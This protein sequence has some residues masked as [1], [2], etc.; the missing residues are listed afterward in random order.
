MGDWEQSKQEFIDK[1]GHADKIF[2]EIFNVDADALVIQGEERDEL[3]K[4]QAANKKILNKLRSREF[5][6]AIVGLEKAG[7][8][9]L[10][11]A[12]IK[13]MV[14]PE[15]ESRCTYTTT[16]IRAG[17]TDIAEV[18]FYGV[19]EFNKNFQRMLRDVQFPNEVDFDAM[20]LETFTRY[21]QTVETES[22]EDPVKR[23]IF[24]LHNGATAEDL[25][26]IL[27]GKNKIKSLLGQQSK[28][29]GAEYWNSN[30]K[31]NEFKTYVTGMTGIN[32]DGTPRRDPS[33]YAVKNI[34]IR[35]TQLADMS[36]IVLYDVP[37]FDS[38]TELHKRQTEEMLKEADAIILV[39]NVG[40]RPNLVGTQL[41]M[42]RKGQDF[43]GVRLSE[44]SFVFGNKIDRV[45]KLETA[46]RN[47]ATLRQDAVDK[48]RITLSNHII[49]GSARAYLEK[50]G[51]FAE[52]FSSPIL[53]E[54]KYPDG[55]EILIKK[56]QEYYDHDR[57][58]VLRRRAENI[59]AKTQPF[60]RKLLERYDD[61]GISYINPGTEIL[62][63][64]QSRLPLFIKSAKKITDSHK[65]R[66]NRER[67]FTTTLK[68]EV[69]KIFPLIQEA[70]TKLIDDIESESFINTDN[71]YPTSEVDKNVRREISKIFTENIVKSAA[72]I[73]SEKQQQLRQELVDSFLTA[74][75]IEGGIFYRADLNKSVN[76]LFDAML[77]EGGAKCS[78]TSLVER[79]ASTPIQALIGEPFTEPERRNKVKEA[80]EE[81]VS[82]A[83]F[84]K[85]PSDAAGKKSLKFE[86]LIEGGENFFAKILAHEGVETPSYTA[87]NQTGDFAEIEK[88]LNKFFTK[89]RKQIFGSDSFNINSL[90]ISNWANIMA[91]ANI[92]VTAILPAIGQLT[93]GGDDWKKL[94]AD[95]KIRAIDQVIR[96]CAQEN[97]TKSFVE[98]KTPKT[99]SRNNSDGNQNSK[100]ETILGMLDEIQ[101]RAEKLKRLDGKEDMMAT[102]NTDIMILRDIT[103]KAVINAIGLER[104]FNSVIVKNVDLIRDHLSNPEGD[105]N[106]IYRAWI[107]KN[108]AK[109]KPT[110]FARI[111]DD[112]TIR[113]SRKAIVNAIKELFVDWN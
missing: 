61:T 113:E 21:W 23:T 48:Y 90:P 58:A 6:V 9:T 15:Y 10:G 37:G 7:K 47:F 26:E 88:T 97:V 46:E 31:F 65:E 105:G 86:Q 75:D 33:P 38:P 25:K 99:K 40:D 63:K 68:S 73:T 60:F 24:N 76:E 13:S 54:W 112:E 108:A 82:F 84:Y 101:E 78:F 107:R 106:E 56:M 4:L 19:D 12:L 49:A 95:E 50:I 111:E 8:S 79:F 3:R 22:A 45:D 94:P 20:T 62:M 81:F 91:E 51:L 110:E 43:D 39:T 34:I 17:D 67:P 29:F 98:S 57:F 77:I 32:A 28:K 18:Y 69:D 70:F 64:I 36:H 66:I 11:N 80:L 100:A 87:P 104:A 14:L 109:L 103:A 1:L 30:D 96:E 72:R 2:G 41:D 102:I 5:T 44:K 93:Y 83:V 55:V 42:L 89:N 16:E 71:V 27:A 85:I 35:S 92:T 52:K 59:L 53:E 74:M